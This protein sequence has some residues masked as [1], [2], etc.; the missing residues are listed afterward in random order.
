MD[1]SLLDLK[2]NGKKCITLNICCYF[3][4]GRTV[5]LSK[6]KQILYKLGDINEENWW[7]G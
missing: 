6:D 2:F 3:E 4:H 1:L 5:S 7:K